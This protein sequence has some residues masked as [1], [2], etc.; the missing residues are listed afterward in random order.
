MGTV[1]NVST[2][3]DVWTA[4]HRSYL[5]MT[6]HW[7]D[8]KSLKSQKAFVA[9]VHITGHRTYDILAGSGLQ[10]KISAT[11]TDNGSNFV[12]AFTSFTVQETEHDNNDEHSIVDDDFVVQ[13][14]DVSFTDLHSVIILD[15]DDDGLTQVEYELPPHQRCAS[16][17]FIA[18]MLKNTYYPVPCQKVY[19]KAPL[20]N[21]LHCGTR[22][23]DQ[24]L[25]QTK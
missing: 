14:D 2:T 6:V 16:H 23:E 15:Q 12:K 21:V 1:E 9:C 13:D 3:A 20:G 5:G 8:D 11:V 24:H 25:L 19:I 22:Q 18:L 4:H 17:T 7:I 10:G